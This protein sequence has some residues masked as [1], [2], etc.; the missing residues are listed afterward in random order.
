MKFVVFRELAT[1]LCFTERSNPGELMVPAGNPIPNG[2]GH[3]VSRK[4]TSSFHNQNTLG[5]RPEGAAGT[6]GKQ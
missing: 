5:K 6:G 2:S 1:T 4:G 3:L